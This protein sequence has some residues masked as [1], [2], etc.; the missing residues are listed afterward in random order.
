[1]L[2]MQSGSP[3]SSSKYNGNKILAAS[4]SMYGRFR[5][6]CSSKPSL[7]SEI[8]HFTLNLFSAVANGETCFNS[9][10]FLSSLE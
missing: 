7:L 2:R 3:S 1:M 10:D 8:Y 4:G 5:I 6:R 9:H